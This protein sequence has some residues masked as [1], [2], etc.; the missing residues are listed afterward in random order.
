MSD[1]NTMQMMFRTN[2]IS[3]M[4][5]QQTNIQEPVYV[6]QITTEPKVCE[7]KS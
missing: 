4:F 6:N 2:N 1:F 5:N 7:Q 3:S